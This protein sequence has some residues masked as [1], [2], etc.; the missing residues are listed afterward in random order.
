MKKKLHLITTAILCLVSFAIQ[1]QFTGDGFYR[2]TSYDSNEYISY[3]I[4]TNTATLQNTETESTAATNTIFKFVENTSNPGKYNLISEDGV[5]VLAR[6]NGQTRAKTR[7]NTSLNRDLDD[8]LFTI[9][10][11][12]TYS[13][14][15]DGTTAAPYGAGQTYLI[16]NTTV[17]DASALQLKYHDTNDIRSSNSTTGSVVKWF[18][19]SVPTTFVG[20]GQYRIKNESNTGNYFT[21]ATPTATENNILLTSNDPVVT[22]TIFNITSNATNSGK[23]NILTS[24]DVRFI[25]VGGGSAT[26]P[27]TRTVSSSDV[28]AAVAVFDIV[29]QTADSY[30]LGF[31]FSAT[32]KYLI[33]NGNDDI[34]VGADP[35]DPLQRWVFEYVGTLPTI[36]VDDIVDTKMLKVYPVPSLDGIFN[37]PKSAAWSVYAVTGTLVAEGNSAQIDISNAP[38]GVYILQFNGITKKIISQ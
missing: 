13:T 18:I 11:S 1:A 16:T 33:D 26:S 21:Y 24:D 30:S 29:R 28:D 15:K 20:E 25:A 14:Y 32:D 2:I 22:E 19:E 34:K 9:S 17:G 10:N 7:E 31:T 36:S 37:L 8:C 5:R 12:S 23:Y 35:T 6:Y 27:L 3:V 4:P 38:K